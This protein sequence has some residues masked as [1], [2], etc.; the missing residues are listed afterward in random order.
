MVFP[1]DSSSSHSHTMSYC[2]N[3]NFKKKS[4]SLRHSPLFFRQPGPRLEYILSEKKIAVWRQQKAHLLQPLTCFR[5]YV[6]GIVAA[7]KANG[8]PKPWTSLES[9]N[10][11]GKQKNLIK[12]VYP[13]TWRLLDHFRTREPPKQ[14]SLRLRD[15]TGL[16]LQRLI[17]ARGEPMILTSDSWRSIRLLVVVT[18]CGHR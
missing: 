17:D 11:L 7:L 4:S 3:V 15:R 2:S 8:N 9:W 5:A 6:C 1:S 18:T 16:P 14:P 12:L 13:P 10:T